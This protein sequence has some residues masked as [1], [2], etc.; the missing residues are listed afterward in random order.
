MAE[1]KELKN[2]VCRRCVLP[3]HKPEIWLNEDGI[4]NICTEFEHKR[5]SGQETRLS[6]TQ[7]IKILDKFKGKSKYDCLL[8][9]SGGKDSVASLY[10]T[11]KRYGLNPFVFTFDNGFENE[12][13]LQNVRNATGILKTDWLY[14]RSKYMKDMYA[15]MI[16][17]K[18]DFPACMLCSLWYM[19]QVYKVA[20]QYNLRLIIGGWTSGQVNVEEREMQV[21]TR[22]IPGFIDLMRKKYPKYRDFPRNM[23]E[24]KKGFGIS[25]KAVIISPHW[26]LPY[27]SEEYVEIIRKELNWKPISFSYPLNSSNC[28]VNFIG[29]FLSMR[30]L[31]FTHFHVEMSKLIR[32][33]KLSRDEAL[34]ALEIDIHHE[35]G[36]SL[37][38]SVLK[39]LGCPKEDLES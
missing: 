25:K 20:S 24:L 12:D 14:F 2:R 21:L 27:G 35:P 19:Q 11:R 16:R 8:M 9:C 36:A 17:M 10:Y 13:A 37:V 39:K 5:S 28:T 6:E 30:L 15:E 3:E 23:S 22:G 31:G 4:C 7:L 18:A 33:N 38:S 34:R 29:S 26:F 1:P 32:S